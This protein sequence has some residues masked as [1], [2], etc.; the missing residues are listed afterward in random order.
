[1][2]LTAECPFYS[3]AWQD[4]AVAMKHMLAV[5]GNSKRPSFVKRWHN[6]RDFG[7]VFQFQKR[8]DVEQLVATVEAKTGLENKAYNKLHNIPPLNQMK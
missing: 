1:M 6:F 3:R 4:F 2:L 8:A 5:P 7:D